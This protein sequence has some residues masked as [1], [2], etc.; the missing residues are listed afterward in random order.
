MRLFDCHRARTAQTEGRIRANENPLTSDREGENVMKTF[1]IERRATELEQDGYTVIHNVMP[2]SNS[3]RPSRRLKRHWT[4]RKPLVANTA[5]RTNIFGMRST[6]RAS[7]R[8]S[9][10]CRSATRNR[11][12]LPVV[13][14]VRT[15]SHTT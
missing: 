4:P 1:D 11:L 10:G 13:C 6:L 9:T 12:R 7:I 5:C 15:C 3:R 8:I 2:P 14:S